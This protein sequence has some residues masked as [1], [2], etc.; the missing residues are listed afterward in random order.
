ML[1][2]CGT[3]AAYN[4]HLYHDQRPCAACREAHRVEALASWH[5]RNDPDPDGFGHAREPCTIYDTFTPAE[6]EAARIDSPAMIQCRS[7]S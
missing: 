6:I 5:R 1:R 7:Q 2:P 4:R 3:T